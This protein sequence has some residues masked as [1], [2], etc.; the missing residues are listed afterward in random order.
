[1]VVIPHLLPKK[2][3][4]FILKW[5]SIHLLKQPLNTGALGLLAEVADLLI[6]HRNQRLR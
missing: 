3:K 6:S 1:M 2:G 5:V 4:Y